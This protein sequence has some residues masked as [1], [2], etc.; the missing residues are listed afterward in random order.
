MNGPGPFKVFYQACGFHRSDQGLEL[1]GNRSVYNVGRGRSR[2]QSE[3][4]ALASKT[5]ELNFI[6][7]LF[8]FEVN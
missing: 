8:S 6:S 7:F 2:G 3:R 5:N 4:K 1:A